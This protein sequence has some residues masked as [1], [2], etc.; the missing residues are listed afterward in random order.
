MRTRRIGSVVGLALAVLLTAA[1]TGLSAPVPEEEAALRKKALALN[2]VTGDGPIKGEIKSLVGDPANSKKLVVIAGRMAKEKP[3]PFN[4]NGAYIL[5]AAALQLQEL[6]ASRALFLVCAEQA[7]KLQSDRKLT[8]AYRGLLAVTDLL[9]IDKKFDKSAKLAQEFLEMLERQPGASP[10]FKNEVLRKWLRAMNKQGKTQEAAKIIDTLVKSKPSAWRNLELKAWFERELEHYDAAAKIYRDVLDRVAKDSEMDKEE[11]AEI[12]A[13]IELS[14][15]DLLFLD[16]KYEQS[17]KMAQELLQKLEKQG[18]AARSRKVV[19]RRLVQALI[20]QGKMD[21]AIRLGDKLSEG[22]ENDLEDLELKGFLRRQAGRYDEA[23]KIYEQMLAQVGKDESLENPERKE[24]EAQIRYMLSGVYVD[25]DQVDKAA[26]HLKA[27]LKQD[28]DNPTYNNDLGYIWIDHDLN[29]DEG[30]KLIRKAI[31]EDRKQRKKR[32]NLEPAE[33]KDNAAY[34]DS[35]G[36]VLFKKKNYK[37]AKKYLLEATQ[38]K[39]GQHIEIMDHLADAHLAL[40]E[41]AEAVAVWKKALKLETPT[42]R[43]KDRKTLVEKKL[44]A[45]Q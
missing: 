20:R 35:L 24:L 38:S 17:S 7:V 28:P 21:E 45:N 4:Y 13:E 22:R 1:R 15:I 23:A 32:P 2:E 34:L 14:I 11:K 42:K 30:E 19:T 25:L 37:E 10:G 41:K 5:A 40:G 43:E 18:A 26:T 44:K 36:W 8:Q 6:D 31:D 39:D 3:Q 29:L 27:L 9:Y 16:K 33:D 12:Q